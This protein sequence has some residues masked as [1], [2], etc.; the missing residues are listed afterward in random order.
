MAEYARPPGGYA[1]ERDAWLE[2]NNLGRIEIVIDRDLLAEFRAL[3]RE[4]GR[5]A[6]EAMRRAIRRAVVLRNTEAA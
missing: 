1:R 6:P 4:E 3:C 2:R 5:T